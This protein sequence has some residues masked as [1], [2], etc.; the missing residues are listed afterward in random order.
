M[1]DI[2]YVFSMKMFINVNTIF[3]TINKLTYFNENKNN[4]KTHKG[5]IRD[6]SDSYPRFNDLIFGANIKS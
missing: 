2:I 4:H 5:L 1:A 3:Y 6:S